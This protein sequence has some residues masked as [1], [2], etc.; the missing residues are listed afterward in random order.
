MKFETTSFKI[1]I[2]DA[3]M[4]MIFTFIII[5]GLILLMTLIN[6]NPR[7]FLYDTSWILQLIYPILYAIFHSSINRNA[8][9]KITD[10]DDVTELKGRIDTLLLYKG[11]L[12][13]DSKTEDLIYDKKT[14]LGRLINC[15]MREKI[16][17]QATE[18]QVSV[19]S[20]KN[21]LD[22]IR[23]KLIKVRSVKSKI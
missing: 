11:Y 19:F 15:F 7:F 17:V 5:N 13:V 6:G 22:F 14:S 3:F 10:I 2:T 16:I 9:L 21:R 12:S 23:S 4:Q 20:K 1:S 18:N 8:V